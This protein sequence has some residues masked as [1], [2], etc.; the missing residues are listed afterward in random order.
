MNRHYRTLFLSDLHLGSKDCKADYL[1][2]LLRQ[3]QAEK[4]YL[5]GDVID[6]WAMSKRSHWPHS[7][8]QV[9]FE[10]EQLAQRGCD[11]IY[12]PGNH[13]APLRR[14][15]GRTFTGFR[16]QRQGRHQMAD[17]RTLLLTHGDEFDPVVYLG[18]LENLL[19]DL[20]YDV[21]LWLNR[22]CA[23][24]RRR[25]K[26]PY[27]SLAGYIKRQV[28]QANAAIRRYRQAALH[29][30]RLA[31]CDGVIL[32]HIHQPECLQIDGMLYL[33]TGDFVDSCSFIAETYSGE[34]ELM[35]WTEQPVQLFKAA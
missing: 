17:G 24:W 23:F 25:L 1:I 30:A 26:L 7:H 27:W 11:I 8:T 14:F 33:N 35:H 4:L 13:D 9:L 6:L 2:N 15:C 3:C 29:A 20:G 21:L 10:L 12:I 5:L 34:L 16:L 28:P 32:G 18:K 31:Q 22:V 19:G